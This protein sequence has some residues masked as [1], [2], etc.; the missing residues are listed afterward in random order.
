[1]S[2]VNGILPSIA[3]ILSG[4]STTPITIFQV[5]SVL[6]IFLAFLKTLRKFLPSVFI[7][8]ESVAPIFFVSPNL[9]KILNGP[10]SRCHPFFIS[11]TPWKF[12][13]VLSRAPTSPPPRA[14]LN[15]LWY[16]QALQSSPSP[17]KTLRNPPRVFESLSSSSPLHVGN[18]LRLDQ[19]LLLLHL[20]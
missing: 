14:P 9:I 12:F 10:F 17:P 11:S 2:L 6:P 15:P 5:T 18:S 16:S 1:M 4:Y 13:T 8:R 7:L 20:L 19:Q 3:P